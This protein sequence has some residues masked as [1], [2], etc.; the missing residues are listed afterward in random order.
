MIYF[1]GL[2]VCINKYSSGRN[3]VLILVYRLVLQTTDQIRSTEKLVIEN[4]FHKTFYI[5]FTC[6]AA[7]CILYCAE[8]KKTS[9]KTPE[10]FV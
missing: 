4:V 10:I 7:H 8:L 5:I 3:F 6:A 1:V 9:N 2:S